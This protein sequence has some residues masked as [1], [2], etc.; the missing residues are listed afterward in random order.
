MPIDTQHP[1]YRAVLPQW[2]RARAILAG[3]DAVKLQGP[4]L[5]PQLGGHDS[6]EYDAYRKRAS[7]YNAASRTAQGYI[8]MVYR[9]PATIRM[10]E[11]LLPMF[12][13]DADLLGTTLQDYGRQV[14]TDV[15]QVGRCGT[16]INWDDL[17]ARPH[18]VLYRAEDI[19]NWQVE[20]VRG[21]FRA[22]R[23]ILREWHNIAADAYETELAPQYRVLRLNT[24][25]VPSVT[26]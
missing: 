7:F 24:S 3:E 2:L 13:T 12:E 22:T 1:E 15:V 11:G 16:L 8:G 6:N 20:R 26:V 10:P 9:R 23:V 4:A 18:C 14:L 5:L 25:P 17:S 21:K 19:I